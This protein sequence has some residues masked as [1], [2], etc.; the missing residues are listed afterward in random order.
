MPNSYPEIKTFKGLYLQKNSFT[1]PDGAMEIAR[2]CIMLQ[3]NRISKTPGH[4]QYF[5]PGSG[6]LNNLFYYQTKLI[7]IYLNKMGYYADT[8]SAPNETGTE[9]LLTGQTIAITSPRVSRSVQASNNLLF[10]T[11]NGV[12]KLDAYNAKI[13]QAGMPPGLDLSAILLGDNGWF[14]GDSQAAYRI[15]FGRRDANANLLLGAPSEQLVLT[16]NVVSNVAYT[17]ST[18]TGTTPDTQT[19]TVTSPLH[20]LATGMT[21]TITGGTGSPAVPN[22]DYTVTVTT[23]NAFTF[24]YLSDTAPGAGNLT[25]E[26]T[27]NVQLEFTIPAEITTAADLYFYQVYRTTAS[28]SAAVSPTPNY[29][30]VEEKVIT[31]AEITAR[32]VFYTDDID[33]VLVTYAPELYTNPNSREGELQSNIKPPKCDDLT[34]FK[35]CVL[36]AKC[37]TRHTLDFDLID[38]GTLSNGSYIEVKVGALTRR[39]VARTGV[40]NTNVVA[41]SVSYSTPTLTITY[42]A[43][44]LING[45]TVYISNVVGTG[46]A[47]SGAYVISNVLTDSFDITQ[48]GITTVTHLE[49][50]GVTNAAG[51]YIFKLDK[52]STSVATQLSTTARGIVKAINRDTSSVVYAFYTSAITDVPGKM[53]LQ[54]QGFG[55]PIYLRA[56]TTTSGSSFQPALPDSF[57]AG[58]Q[59]Y[60]QNEDKP[61]SIFSSK[62]G[63]TEATPIANEFVAGSRNAK[64]YRIFSLRDS[65]II[66]KADGVF[67][68]TGD[69]P[70]NF[71]ITAVDNTIFCLSAN[72][73]TLLNNQVYFLSNQGVCVVTE[74]AAQI[75]SREKIEDVILPILGKTDLELETGAVGFESQRTYRL[76]T[77]GPNDNVK[78]ITYI[79]NFINDTWTSQDILFKQGVIGAND[80]LYLLTYGNKIFK[81]RK[82]QTRIDFCGQNYSVTIISVASNKMSASIT[83]SSVIPQ[84]GDVIVKN[85][86][87][88]RIATVTMTASSTYTVTFRTTT[89]LL[90]SDSVILYQGYETEID[91]APFH[92]G[93]VGMMK[94]F[95]QMQIHTRTPN[96]TKLTLNFSG[97]IYG[98]SETT[99]WVNSNVYSSG[100]LGWG[101]FPWGFEPWGQADAI[102]IYQ[103]TVPAPPIRIYIP[104]FQQ[105]NTFIK[106]RLIHREA[107]ESLD[108]QALDYVVRPYKERVSK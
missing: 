8:G 93:Q 24:A 27:R 57:V 63:E 18:N 103:G 2:N 82:T 99:E 15:V 80:S 107:G 98:G 105:R 53:Q 76:S 9:T 7:S 6:T 62:P 25:Y 20:G 101:L 36:Y 67:R 85:D 106:M 73:A 12:L 32:R 17:V 3:D 19:I 45:D 77:I 33:E 16:N 66:L 95:S 78:T 71:S 28:I 84:E 40:A 64:I 55:V 72:S 104:R 39:Y 89:T 59:V 38:T 54:A 48:A 37:V 69:G 21:I 31:A 46:T 70:S 102:D 51:Y 81:E 96:I 79:Y 61:N 100:I 44:G 87:F 4:Y 74:T 50:E 1:V 108:I 13:F 29:R 43:H 26:A 22:G 92:A 49:F 60:S 11:D 86:T 65:T 5:A 14:P 90:A 88:S 83:S 10:T 35:N 56:D 58:N 42:V 75:L 47:P 23:I 97:Y 30:L 68:L 94:Q 41:D 34:L 91:F 52:T